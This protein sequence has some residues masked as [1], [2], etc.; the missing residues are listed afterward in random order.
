MLQWLTLF[1]CAIVTVSEAPECHYFTKLPITDT[2]I[3]TNVDVRLL[4][5]MNKNSECASLINAT[6]ISPLDVKKKT[7]FLIHGYRPFG[8]PPNWLDKLIKTLLNVDDIN[9]II[10]DWNRG[11]TTINYSTAVTNTKKV[12]VILKP[13]IDSILDNGGSFDSI[14]LIG[15]SLGA[16][17]SGFVGS[18]FDGKIGRIT[19]LD[20]AGPLFREKGKDDR[21]DPSDAMLVDVLHTDVDALGYRDFLGHIDYYA[22]GGTDQPGCPATIL[23]GKKYMVCDHQRSVY[24]YISSMNSPCNIT[25]YPCGSYA[26]FLDGR[27]TQRDSTYPIFGYHLDKWANSSSVMGFPNKVFFQTSS[28]EPFCMYYYLLVI[29]PWNKNARKGYITIELADGN[30][31]KVKS[32]DNHSAKTFERFRKVTFLVSVDKDLKNITRISLKYSSAHVVEHK[33]TLG[34]LRLELRSLS[35]PDRPHLCRYDVALERDEEVKVQP[36]ECGVQEM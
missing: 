17:I 32:K 20:P 5:Y 35:H 15:V 10:V 29:I 6:H 34:I 8:S 4:L 26:E 28:E 12:A 33:L 3:G 21:L 14:H 31:L 11:A 18:M 16:H 36:F 27:C 1:L 2:L 23:S 7:I 30:G 24:L 13:V 19:G 9:L 25:N 22:N